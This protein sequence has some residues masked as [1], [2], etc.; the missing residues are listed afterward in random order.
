MQLK[1]FFV[2]LFVQFPLIAYALQPSLGQTVQLTEARPNRLSL[3]EAADRVQQRSGGRILAAQAI[4]ETGREV[5]RIKILTSQGEV[6][7]VLVDAAT[8]NME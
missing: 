6:R 4:R 3:S 1:M 8:G 5:Y 7:I 2:G